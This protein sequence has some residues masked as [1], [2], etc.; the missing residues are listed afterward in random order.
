MQLKQGI[1]QMELWLHRTT[2]ILNKYDEEKGLQTNL[3]SWIINSTKERYE[4]AEDL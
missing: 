1:T 4:E 3:I 2:I